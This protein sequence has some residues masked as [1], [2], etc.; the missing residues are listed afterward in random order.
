MQRFGRGEIIIEL[1]Q[2]GEEASDFGVPGE[3]LRIAPGG[4]SLRH[5]KSPIEKIARVRENLRGRAAAGRLGEGSKR[6]GCAAQSLA[7]AIGDRGYGVAEKLAGGI[8]R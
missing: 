1:F 4:L 2:A 5:R 6:F 3:W 7:A 8:V